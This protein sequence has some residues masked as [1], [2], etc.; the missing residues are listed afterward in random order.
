MKTQAPQTKKQ[1]GKKARPKRPKVDYCTFV[2]EIFDW[3]LPYS[4]SIHHDSKHYPSPYTRVLF[5]NNNFFLVRVTTYF[6]IW[7]YTRK[8]KKD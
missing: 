1:T 4:F 6:V 8:N 5:R 7:H 3:E 2:V